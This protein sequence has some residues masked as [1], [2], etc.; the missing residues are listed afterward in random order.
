MPQDLTSM[1][2]PRSRGQ[3]TYSDYKTQMATL[4]SADFSIF[5]EELDKIFLIVTKKAQVTASATISVEE[6]VN[7]IYYAAK[8]VMINMMQRGLRNSRRFLIDLLAARDAN[9]DGY[10]E[11]QEFEDMLLQDLQ[12]NFGPKLYESLVI[13]QLLDPGKR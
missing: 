11:Y 12:V 5:D 3:L 8:A 1:I 6:L 10:L 2:D 13:S 4:R 9:Q 7:A